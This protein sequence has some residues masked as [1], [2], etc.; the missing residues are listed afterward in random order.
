[1]PVDWHDATDFPDRLRDDRSGFSVDVL[2]WCP[3]ADEH[4]VGWL[5]YN[6][7]R[8]LFLCRQAIDEKFYW[9]YFDDKTDRVKIKIIAN[10]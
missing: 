7:I 1:M 9:R 10:K 2:V 6:E 4:T 5:D 8:W 3:T